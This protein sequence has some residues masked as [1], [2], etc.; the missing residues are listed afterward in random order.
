MLTETLAAVRELPD[1]GFMARCFSSL[2]AEI[3][4][5]AK[6]RKAHPSPYRISSGQRLHQWHGGRS[7]DRRRQADHR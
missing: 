7:R 5:L 4:A 2:S 3:K 1:R 6:P